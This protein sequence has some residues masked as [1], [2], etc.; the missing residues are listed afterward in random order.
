MCHGGLGLA[1]RIGSRRSIRYPHSN[2][3]RT[4]KIMTIP[5]VPFGALTDVVPKF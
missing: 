2:H 5:Y 1:E 3:K 4:R